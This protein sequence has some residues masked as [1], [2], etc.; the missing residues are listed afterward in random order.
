[1]NMLATCRASSGGMLRVPGSTP[2]ITLDIITLPIRLAFGIGF[3]CAKPGKFTLCRFAITLLLQLSRPG[4]GLLP[5]LE[6]ALGFLSRHREETDQRT[7]AGD[8][9][10][11]ELVVERARQRFLGDR[12]DDVRRDHDDAVA[13][14]NDDVS[15]IDRHSAAADRQIEVCRLVDD[16]AR[17]R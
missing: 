14:A 1:M 5:S 9:L 13:I 11:G 15:G 3:W 6:V 16:A 8:F 17:R 7:A 10:F 12:V 2:L 4:A